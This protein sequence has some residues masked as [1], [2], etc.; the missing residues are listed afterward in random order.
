MYRTKLGHVHIKVSDLNRSI[1]FYTRFFNLKVVERIGSHYAF[2]SGSE[3]HHELALQNVGPHA[4]Q[5]EPDGIGLYHIA[6]EVPDRASFANA[7]KT[8]T[9]AEIEVYP[10]NHFISWALYFSD[11]DGNGLEIYL[12][13]RKESQG[14][15][16]WHG[17]SEPLSR[18][19]ILQH[20]TVS[21]HRQE[22]KGV[23]P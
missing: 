17:Y 12:D 20:D 19:E 16:L 10:V 7:Y 13:T 1:E 11:P 21:E 9:N 3:A 15:H 18:E 4:P 8:L 5:P 23:N 14:D 2:L 6:F 22:T